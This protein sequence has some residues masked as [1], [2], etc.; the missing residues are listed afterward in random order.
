[1]RK[2]EHNKVK[3]YMHKVN[4]KVMSD[5]YLGLNR[6]R[7][8][9]YREFWH[10]YA[11]NSGGRLTVYF[12]LTDTLTNNTA[13]FVANN[14]DYERQILSYFNDFLIRCSSGLSGNFPPLH[15]VQYDVHE[16]VDYKGNKC[17]ERDESVVCAYDYFKKR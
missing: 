5:S 9:S 8:D 11:D 4:N 13:T 17:T 12:K 7:I 10:K 2:R 3:R 15:Y 16:I 1:M 6:F 14:Y